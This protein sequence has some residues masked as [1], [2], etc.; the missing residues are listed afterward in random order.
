MWCA[1]DAAEKEENSRR[2]EEQ[3]RPNSSASKSRMEGVA[4]GGSVAAA[5]PLV[6]TD[7]PASSPATPQLAAAHVCSRFI[8]LAN[9][10]KQWLWQLEDGEDKGVIDAGSCDGADGAPYQP[11]AG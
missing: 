3:Q 5:T 6:A 4:Q 9:Q 1:E 2:T 8:K 7:E 11:L 10:V